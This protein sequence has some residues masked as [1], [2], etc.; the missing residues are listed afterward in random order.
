MLA[1]KSD[2][3]KYSICVTHLNN[4]PTVRA[5]LD[6]ILNQIDARFEVVVVDGASTDGSWEILREYSQAGKIRL[7][8]KKCS[9]GLGRQVAFNN[10]VGDFIIANLDLDDVFEPSLGGLLELYHARCDGKLLL[11]LGAP[12]DS[13]TWLPNVTLASRKL[14]L[15]LGGWR[16]LQI[17]EDWDIWCRAS[18]VG[19]FRTTEFPL[20]RE[21]GSQ[22]KGRSVIR[23]MR[24]RYQT[25]RDYLKLGRT[26]FSPG[27]QVSSSQRAILILARLS[28]HF[29]PS[30]AE[31]YNRTFNP[32]DLKYFIGNEASS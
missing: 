32:Y 30:Y 20:A 15:R 11:A 1:L 4:A 25:Y 10:S 5:S 23:R 27:E 22:S 28:A 14:I 21:I 13:Q 24:R 31:D 18:K 17:G 2:L 6:S 12:P 7:F 19:E 16:D 26:V 29:G 8:Q 3:L 9:R